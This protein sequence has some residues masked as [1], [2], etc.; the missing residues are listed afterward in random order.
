MKPSQ[1]VLA[2]AYE[3]VIGP[4]LGHLGYVS[5]NVMKICKVTLAQDSTSVKEALNTAK[6]KIKV[7]VPVVVLSAMLLLV[8]HAKGYWTEA[9]AQDTCVSSPLGPYLTDVHSAG[10]LFFQDVLRSV[11]HW[12][13]SEAKSE[14]LG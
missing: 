11:S 7:V 8:A 14:R 5:T 3:L 12:V 13:F 4:I 9:T 10:K 2:L 6:P 1:R